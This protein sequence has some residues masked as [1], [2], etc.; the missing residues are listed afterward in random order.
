MK[1]EKLHLSF[2]IVCLF[3]LLLVWRLGN[4]VV[5]RLIDVALTLVI[6]NNDDE[7]NAL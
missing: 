2:N 4:G 1:E 6:I 3:F 5:S 7:K